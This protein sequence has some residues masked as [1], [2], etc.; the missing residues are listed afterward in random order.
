M[1]SIQIPPGFGYHNGR[2]A[3]MDPRRLQR[4]RQRI[5]GQTPF[6]GGLLRRMTARSLAREG[7]PE[8]IGLLAET[9]VETS[10][11]SLRAAGL[12]ALRSQTNQSS[13]DSVCAVWTV[14]RSQVLADLISERDW[15]AVN[16]PHVKTLTALQAQHW[17][18][19]FDAGAEMVEALVAACDDADPEIARHARECLPRLQN[20]SAIDA[21]CL[22]WAKK[23]ENHLAAAISQAGYVACR[24]AELR[25]LS[26]LQAGRVD[27]IRAGDAEVVEP[28]LQAC[29]DCDEAISKQAFSTLHHLSQPQAQEALC[30]LV[31]QQE[32]PLAREAV[33]AAQYAPGD[34]TARSLFYFL[35]NQWE[36][37]DA[38]DFDQ[39]L[40]GAAYETGDKKLRCRIAEKARRAGRTEWV[41][42]IIGG[43]QER[44]VNELTDEEWEAALDVLGESERWSEIWRLAQAAS[45]DWCVRMLDRLKGSR[46]KPED[47]RERA[48]FSRLIELAGACDHEPPFLGRLMRCAAPLAGHGGHVSCFAVSRDG[49]TLVSG[50]NDNTLRL[51]N[52]TGGTELRTVEG[53]TDWIA[54]V[55]LSSDESIFASGSRD[56]TVGLWSFP[57]GNA[58]KRLEGH[59]E[60]IRCLAFS[61]DGRLLATGSADKTVRIWSVPD[62]Q[63]VATLKEHSDIVSCLAISPDGR[64]LATGSYDNHVRLWSLPKGE[65]AAV[66]RGHK[67][68]VNCLAFSPD[69]SALATGSK[70]RSVLLWSLPAG[71]KLDRLKGH[72]DDVSCLAISPDGRILA[73]G[74]WD[75]TIRLWS[76]PSGELLDTLGAMGTIDGHSGWVTCLAFSPDGLVLA[77]GGSDNTVRLWSVP[78]GAPLKALEEHF[79][80]ISC[81][82]FSAD[83][84]ALLSGSWDRRVCLWKSDL[85]RLRQL[86]VGRTSLEDLKWTEEVLAN[87]K[88]SGAERGWLEFLLAL[89]RWRRRH[90][91]QLGEP[92]RIPVGQFDIEIEG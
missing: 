60:D 2:I 86:P 79:D 84:R 55:A 91:I 53:H 89:M 17:H 58:V 42:V 85:A 59:G 52:L 54:C 43:R 11:E 44:R 46:W 66:L 27:L 57:E 80:R 73:S 9:V 22:R 39:S 7:S 92:A 25:V 6:V 51:W 34:P 14:S 90:D 63:P 1:I 83:G 78:G 75:S 24:P 23:R 76:L 87:S 88:L 69:S 37:Y 35:T 71:T 31:M 64:F 36:K 20:P 49:R 28:L 5:R 81:L 77:S 12:R 26:A 50:G 30:R 68:M 40:L 62:G 56:R 21:L 4:Y 82:S 8:A 47:G 67:A 19:I 70:D 61:P 32:L 18:I 16:P 29:R 72:K 45:A 38:L 13:I 3:E 15:L 41:A 65:S 74:S 10:D 33:V 48:G